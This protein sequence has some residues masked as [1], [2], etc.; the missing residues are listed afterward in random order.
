MQCNAMPCHAALLTH[1]QPILEQA[2]KVGTEPRKK[3]QERNK[4][5]ILLCSGL[6]RKKNAAFIIPS[7]HKNADRPD[8]HLIPEGK[9]KEPQSPDYEKL[10]QFSKSV[11][12]IPLARRENNQHKCP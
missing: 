5:S 7:I 9:K 10:R 8:R 2:A 1:F 12:V 6:E 4:S 11:P 3:E